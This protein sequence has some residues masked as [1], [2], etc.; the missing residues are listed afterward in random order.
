MQT[1][2]TLN[3]VK[4]RHV[5]ASQEQYQNARL[6]GKAQKQMRTVF[7]AIGTEINEIGMLDSFE[8]L[9]VLPNVRIRVIFKDGEAFLRQ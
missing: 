5:D 2:A 4:E 9:A 3:V 6:I 8:K 1:V 7:G